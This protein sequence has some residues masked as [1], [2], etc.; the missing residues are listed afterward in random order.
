MEVPSL[1]KRKPFDSLW[2]HRKGYDALAF[3]SKRSKGV[4]M[5]PELFPGELSPQ[6]QHPRCFD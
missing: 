5:N 6:L 4:K 1:W 3:A 2:T